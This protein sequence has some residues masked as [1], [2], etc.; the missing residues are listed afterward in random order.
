MTSAG[1]VVHRF[2]AAVGAKDFVAARKLL[3]DDL[4]F[5]GPIDTFH[6]ADDYV[7]A[8]KKLAGI[9]KGV[10]VKKVFVDGNEVCVL[11]DMITNTPAGTS[12]ISEWFR[13]KGDRISEIRVVF[14]ARPFAAMF[15]K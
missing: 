8:I 4:S 1:E 10:E 2:H 3:H 5:K 15:A 11:Y 6:K 7:E 14:D 13:T 12:F 9:V